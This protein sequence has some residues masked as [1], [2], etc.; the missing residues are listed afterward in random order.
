MNTWGD[1]VLLVFGTA[2]EAGQLALNLDALVTRS[3]WSEKGLPDDLS[4]RIGLHAG[5]VHPITDPLT[6]DSDFIGTHMTRAARLVTIAPPGCIYASRAFAALAALE[7][8]DFLVCEYVGEQPLPKAAG[9]E[10]TFRLWRHPG[11]PRP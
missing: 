11:D 5:P 6:G 9:S 1:A 8:A 7:G 4:L 10:P 3:P 2:S